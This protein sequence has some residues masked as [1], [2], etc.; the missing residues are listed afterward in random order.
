MEILNLQHLSLFLDQELLVLPEDIRKHQLSEMLK[1]RHA[2]H[3]EEDV[4]GDVSSVEEPEE[5][6]LLINYEGNF[7]K[8]VLICYEG[9]ELEKE[10]RVFLLKI[11]GAVGY[12]LKDVA[13]VSGT[14]LQE[15]PEKSFNQLNPHTC[16]IFGSVNH[17]SIPTKTN[18]YEILNGEVVFLFADDLKEI[19][20]NT[21]L[22]KKLWAILQVLFQINK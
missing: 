21:S 12:S 4:L 18:N 7:E 2:Y 14:Q 9:K 22:K 11:L 16:L 13:L 17:P 1:A 8:G 20:E 5:E 10:T 6:E 19:E 3:P 15:S